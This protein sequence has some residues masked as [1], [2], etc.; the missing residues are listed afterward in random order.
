MPTYKRHC[1]E[2]QIE[3]L[4]PSARKRFCAVKCEKAFNNRRMTRGAILYDLFMA[5]RYEREKAEKLTRSLMSRLAMRFR[6]EDQGR[7]TWQD[8]ADTLDKLPVVDRHIGPLPLPGDDKRKA[9]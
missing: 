3:F 8:L 1:K 4:A 2:C 9:A 7:K 6:D 5:G